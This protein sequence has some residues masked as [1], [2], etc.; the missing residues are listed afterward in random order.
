MTIISSSIKQQ[1][2]IM[3]FYKQLFSKSMKRDALYNICLMLANTI[4]NN[5]ISSSYKSCIEMLKAH[6]ISVKDNAY[7]EAFTALKKLGIILKHNNRYLLNPAVEANYTSRRYE[8]IIDYYNLLFKDTAFELLTLD[9]LRNQAVYSYFDKIA[10]RNQQIEYNNHL[11]EKFGS[12]QFEYIQ[13]LSPK[14]FDEV[15]NLAFNTAKPKLLSD[16]DTP[17]YKSVNEAYRNLCTNQATNL[18][19]QHIYILEEQGIVNV[20]WGGKGTKTNYTFHKFT[21]KAQKALISYDQTNYYLDNLPIPHEELAAQLFEDTQQQLQLQFEEEDMSDTALSDSMVDTKNSSSKYYGFSELD[22][23]PDPRY[24]DLTYTFNTKNQVVDKYSRLKRSC[25]I[26]PQYIPTSVPEEIINQQQLSFWADLSYEDRLIYYRQN[27]S[28][29][30]KL[31]KHLTGSIFIKDYD[32]LLFRMSALI[33]KYLSG[34]DT[35]RTSYSNDSL[36]EEQKDTVAIIR[37]EGRFPTD[38][39]NLPIDIHIEL[40]TEAHYKWAANNNLLPD[41]TKLASSIFSS[42]SIR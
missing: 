38:S 35:S 36:T 41:K 11:Y 40:C 3:E 8:L 16:Y 24:E 12:P 14:S 15:Y 39:D 30:N 2:L 32:E 29:F 18:F 33:E 31:H 19:I 42:I 1:Q 25:C 28:L 37:K 17:I 27:P 23:V 5:T 26:L 13:P 7:T 6:D 20:Q 9:E 21:L 4:K 34:R 10:E 22:D